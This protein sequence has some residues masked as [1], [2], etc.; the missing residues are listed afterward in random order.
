MF[1]LVFLTLTILFFLGNM[2]TIG[3]PFVLMEWLD[4]RMAEWK[5][6]AI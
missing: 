3:V 5:A 1:E 4:K 2:V 6:V